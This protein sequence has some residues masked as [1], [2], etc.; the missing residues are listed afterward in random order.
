MSLTVRADCL[1]VSLAYDL[2]DDCGPEEVQ[3]ALAVLLDAVRSDRWR[4]L[5]GAVSIMTRDGVRVYEL[6]SLPLVSSPAPGSGNAGN[7]GGAEAI[8][9]ETVFCRTVKRTENDGKTWYRALPV[10]QVAGVGPNG[11]WLSSDHLP[12]Y[13]E[14]AGV[15]LE[16][17]DTKGTEHNP[18]RLDV[19]RENGKIRVVKVLRAGA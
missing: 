2:L 10:G 5:V 1:G 16:Q 3:A 15:A 8:Q 18:V 7:A 17:V 13:L 9:L 6:P 12:G 4:A 19:R 14:A 11:I